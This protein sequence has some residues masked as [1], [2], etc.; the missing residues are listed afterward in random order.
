MMGNQNDKQRVCFRSFMEVGEWGG[1]TPM[2]R[3]GG[4]YRII[5]VRGERDGLRV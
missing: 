4:P 1:M 5:S 2:S 3:V